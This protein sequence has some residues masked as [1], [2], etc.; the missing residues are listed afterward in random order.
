MLEQTNDRWGVA[1][2]DGVLVFSRSVQKH[3][4]HLQRA[5]ETMVRKS[6]SMFAFFVRA[7]RFVGVRLPAH[8]VEPGHKKIGFFRRELLPLCTL[9]D[10][11]LSV[12]LYHINSAIE[13][14]MQ[15]NLGMDSLTL[16][17]LWWI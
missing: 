11:L 6:T 7:V 2:M 12:A 9:R 17:P 4:Q 14:A 3:L 10:G 1:Y 5:S 15:A 16:P 8:D 13:A